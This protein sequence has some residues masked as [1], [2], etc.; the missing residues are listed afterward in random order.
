[1]KRK[2]QKQLDR[3]F[4]GTLA[5]ND[6]QRL[7]A[8]L[9]HDPEL[10]QL[11]NQRVRAERLLAGA[12][13]LDTVEGPTDE[14]FERLETLILTANAPEKR[15]ARVGSMVRWASLALG[16]SLALLLMVRLQRE[17]QEIRSDHDGLVARS[18]GGQQRE[19]QL[20]AFC[21]G[22]DGSHVD[23]ATGDGLDCRP[24]EVV[25][26]AAQT[27]HGLPFLVAI[28]VNED[29]SDALD[30]VAE[31]GESVAVPLIDR[32]Q[33][34]GKPIEAERAAGWT[35]QAMFSTEVISVESLRAAVRQS[36]SPTPHRSTTD[37]QPGRIL[38][39]P[40]RVVA[41]SRVGDENK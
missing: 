9:R 40:I 20:T 7:F 39:I 16:T 1:M 4:Q 11:Y 41:K 33:P 36:V 22:R 37:E 5:A 38:S 25:Q 29:G 34:V 23:E 13:N 27:R 15:V 10:R 24:G 35:I 2:E 19:P 26:L 12:G 32:L 6:A 3:W 8:K 18:S 30:L 31:N 17:Q 14:Q 21:V 28:A